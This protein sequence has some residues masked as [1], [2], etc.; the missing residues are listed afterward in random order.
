[1]W[2]EYMP[3]SDQVEYML[4]PRILAISEVGWTTKAN[5]NYEAFVPRVEHFVNRLELLEYNYANHFEDKISLMFNK[6][7][8]Y[9]FHLNI[10]YQR[11]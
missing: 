6:H 9:H 7:L 11:K 8:F 4:F 3:T 2:T 10:C 1:M 5:K